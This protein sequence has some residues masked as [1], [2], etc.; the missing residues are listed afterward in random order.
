ML[1][2]CYKKME[3]KKEIW[4]EALT[5]LGI[6]NINVE[7][8]ERLVKEEASS[9]NEMINLNLQ[10]RLSVRKQACKQFNELFGLTGENAIDV[11]VR[12]DL[13]NMIKK[14]DSIASDYIEKEGDEDV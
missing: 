12:S 13:N 10:A 1:N 6:N 2:K 7:K 4:N 14:Y 3:Y 8:K 11:R 5:Y 9:N